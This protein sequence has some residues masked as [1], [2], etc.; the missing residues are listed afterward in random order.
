MLAAAMAA[1]PTSPAARHAELVRELQAHAYRYY[2]LDDPTVSDAEYDALY[3]ELVLLEREHPDLVS[4]DS[5]TQR[6]G[7]RPREGFVKVTRPVRMLSLDNAYSAAELEEFHR[8]VV[9][10]LPATE[11]P[12]YC[13]EPKLDGASVEVVYEN[14]ALVQA[15]TR[16]DG[17]TGEE[18]TDAIRT[19]RGLPVRID[20]TGR[21]T[22]RGEVLIYRA[23]LERINRMREDEGQEPFANPRNAA[24]G[25]LRL[26]DPRVVARRP[27]RVL[28]YQIVEGP[29]RASCHSD[30]LRLIAEL[31][32]P[33]HRRE[34]V[35]ASMTEV[36]QAIG[37]I[38][39][40][41]ASYP[42]E[43]DGAVVKVD[44]Y[45]QQQI[46][47]ET[48]KIPRWAVAFK[49]GAERAETRVREVVVQV[50]RTGALTPVAELDPV[51]LAGTTVSR[52]S[53]HNFDV[54][55]ALD[56]RVGDR[57]VIQKAGE[58]IP[59]VVAVR[60]QARTGEERP[61]VAPESCPVCGAPSA[62]V[63]EEA[64]VR[65]TS[66]S[67]PGQVKAQLHHYARRFAM[68]VDHLG[69][70]VI[71]QLVDRGMVR[72]VSD[73]Y[74][75]TLEEVAGLERMGPK[76]AENLLRE[77]DASRARTLDRLLCGVGIPQIGQVAAK[78][79]AEVAVS[80]DALLSWS[81][82]QAREATAQIHGFGPTMVEEVV[83]F[84]GDPGQRAVLEKL[85]SLGVGRDQPLA[86]QAATG[87]LAGKSLC[88]TGVLTR[89]REEVHEMI[90]GAGGMVHDKVKKGTS[91]LVAGD[92]VGKSKTDA[93]RK[94]GVEVISE[95]QL[96]GML[97]PRG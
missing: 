48:A 37:A 94:L 76:S 73:L 36:L 33:S 3:R 14:G 27:L 25:S 54:V 91:Y 93:A 82:E 87:P 1:P 92:K 81:P 65:C 49:F 43:T 96:V 12:R 52:A 57:V 34:R 95:Q 64:V 53:L 23:D 78:Q 7:D 68:D 59:Q 55:A 39:Q 79:L 67:C 70:A 61:I 50:G 8:R 10:L 90:R 40:A 62:R 86:K 56:V 83:R 63:A 41:R 26:L 11:A 77:I 9:S 97:G 31:G 42:F 69:P 66:R 44:S 17:T 22:L 85:R 30:S 47:G 88:V 13:V 89:K 20:A 74:G 35:C 2:V 5:P 38:D 28:L 75:L 24:A 60:P 32:M 46:L 72:E 4:A 29:S 58:I 80:L 71:E 15:T 84:L 18:I 19:V 21:L 45:R 6:V 51:P 16:G